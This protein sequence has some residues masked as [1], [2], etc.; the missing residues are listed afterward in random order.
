MAQF[1]QPAPERGPHSACVWS[2]LRPGMLGAGDSQ[3][4]RSAGWFVGQM[5]CFSHKS[6]VT[7][8][9]QGAKEQE[10]RPGTGP[11]PRV[12]ERSPTRA[13]KT[14]GDSQGGQGVCRV[15]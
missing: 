11:Q 14:P 8:E 9:S 15:T 2:R 7:G 4:D 13:V 5:V 3:P 12:L 1:A 6:A 10:G